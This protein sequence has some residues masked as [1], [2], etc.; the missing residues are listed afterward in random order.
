MQI[1]KNKYASASAKKT[2]LIS[3]YRLIARLD[4]N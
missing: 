2:S 4:N 3:Y 1:K